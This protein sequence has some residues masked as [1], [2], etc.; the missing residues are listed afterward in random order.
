MVTLGHQPGLVTPAHLI[1]NIYQNPKIFAELD[2]GRY[3][4]HQRPATIQRPRP[5]QGP[6]LCR[7]ATLALLPAQNLLFVVSIA[8]FWFPVWSLSLAGKQ[9]QSGKLFFIFM[10]GRNEW[11]KH[12]FITWLK[13]CCWWPVSAGGVSTH[14]QQLA[15]QGWSAIVLVKW[16]QPS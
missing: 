16:L 11:G 4:H 1:K 2:L 10:K 14:C 7:M 6:V 8:P 13:H 12:N 15:S 3:I 9:S 5:P